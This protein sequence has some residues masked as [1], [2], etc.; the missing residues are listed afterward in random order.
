MQHW[1]DSD[2][3]SIFMRKYK[4]LQSNFH[5]NSHARA[6]IWE[7]EVL[8]IAKANIFHVQRIFNKEEAICEFKNKKTA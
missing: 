1:K 4:T 6:P 8:A 5:V 3:F 2:S 7:C